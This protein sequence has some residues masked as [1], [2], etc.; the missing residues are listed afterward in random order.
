MGDENMDNMNK[1]L[2]SL[3]ELAEQRQEVYDK[4]YQVYTDAVNSMTAVLVPDEQQVGELFDGLLT[5]C[6]D[7]RFTELYKRLC[8]HIFALYP[9]LK[10]NYIQLYHSKYETTEY[11]QRQEKTNKQ[12]SSG[13]TAD[14]FLKT[15]LMNAVPTPIEKMDKVQRQV[16]E[17]MNPA[18]QQKILEGYPASIVNLES[19]DTI[20]KFNIENFHMPKHAIESFARRIL[21]DI[22][23]SFSN[24]EI[25]KEF[26]EW[27]KQQ[28]K[29][30]KKSK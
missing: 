25:R 8:R 7:K 23:E 20:C 15:D 19:G 18:E 1:T 16:F 5:F 14:I 11:E 9:N 26:E 29:E 24:E 4:A 13:G 21:P 12:R 28:E 17:K 3:N 27:K 30:N 10:D 22:Q 6:D 2:E